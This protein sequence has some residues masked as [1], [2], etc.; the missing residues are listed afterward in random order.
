MSTTTE[1]TAP[2]IHC[3]L[4]PD[5]HERNS[6]HPCVRPRPHI[7][8]EVWAQRMVDAGWPEHAVPELLEMAKRHGAKLRSTNR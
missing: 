8:D 6:T 3:S 1:P 7:P 5:P 4:D 2:L